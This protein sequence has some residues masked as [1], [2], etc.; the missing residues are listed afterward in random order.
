MA[1][2]EWWRN[3]PDHPDRQE[4]KQAEFL[5]HR[6]VP[7]DLIDTIGV[8]DVEAER[9]VEELLVAHQACQRPALRRERSWYY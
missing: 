2:L 6:E 7:W 5:V 1:Y 8:Y 9:R 3:D 4:K